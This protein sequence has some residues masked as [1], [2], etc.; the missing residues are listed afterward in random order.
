MS[1]YEPLNSGLD[2]VYGPVIPYVFPASV[3]RTVLNAFKGIV[4]VKHSR[5]GQ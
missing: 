4:N 1:A 5:P 3:H 2:A